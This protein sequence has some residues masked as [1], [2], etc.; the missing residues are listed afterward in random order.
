M[1]PGFSAW[2]LGELLSGAAWLAE[3]G[4]F[5]KFRQ[6]LLLRCGEVKG[7]H[8]LTTPGVI[9]P[10]QELASAN[11]VRVVDGS[12]VA[13]AHVWSVPPDAAVE[14]PG[15]WRRCNRRLALAAPTEDMPELRPQARGFAISAQQ[16]HGAISAAAALGILVAPELRHRAQCLDQHRPERLS[17]TGVADRV[18]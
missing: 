12:Q 3:S 9:P 6:P 17:A 2:P 7:L 13:A 15:V 4:G 1:G 18:V 14:P 11:K 10:D 16:C 8:A 5:Q